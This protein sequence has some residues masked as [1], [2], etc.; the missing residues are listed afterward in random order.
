VPTDEDGFT[1]AENAFMRA[2]FR[3]LRDTD[4]P[5]DPVFD[6]EA[7]LADLRARICAVSEE[8]TE[9]ALARFWAAVAKMDSDPAEQV[10]IAVLAREDEA[11]GALPARTAA[12][13]PAGSV[14]GVAL[15]Q[16]L[17]PGWGGRGVPVAY[18]SAQPSPP[19]DEYRV[20][21]CGCRPE[22][23]QSSGT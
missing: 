14:N 13:T 21:G 1:E 7:G 19:G 15:V 22:Q 20:P 18:V 2:L 5:G 23:E 16:H 4:L 12:F 17:C 3:Q 9:A 6:V 11:D 8:E 10:R